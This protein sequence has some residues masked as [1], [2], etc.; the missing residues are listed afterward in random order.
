MSRARNL[1]SAASYTPFNKAGDTFT[2]DIYIN[3]NVALRRA[4][5]TEWLLGVGAITGGVDISLG[6]AASSGANNTFGFYSGQKRSISGN[7]AGRVSMPYQPAFFAYGLP[8]GVNNYANAV[9]TGGLTFANTVL[10]QGNRWDGKTFTA[11]VA[12]VYFMHFSQMYHH[13]GGDISFL[14]Q[15]GGTSVA[16]N[17]PYGLDN[18]GNYEQWSQNEVSWIG[19]MGV[20]DKITF[21]WSSSQ[22]ASTYLYGS[23]LYT[24]VMGHLIG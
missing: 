18:V 9:P 24:R 7:A 11:D 5:G 6:T 1:A 16:Y 2:G 19:T 4:T 10:N 17:N 14:I 20:G 23:G 13:A 8:S 21:T 3:D 22:N 15:L 12:G